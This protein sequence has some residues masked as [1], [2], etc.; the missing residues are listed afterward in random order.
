MILSFWEK[1]MA[2]VFLRM[3]DK[4]WFLPQAMALSTAACILLMAELS[5]KAE[6][7]RL[8]SLAK[9]HIGNGPVSE[10]WLRRPS[11]ERFHSRGDRTPPCGVP[12]IS[13]HS[14]CLPPYTASEVLDLR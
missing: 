5:D 11:K 6:V 2:I 4:L 7:M 13:C 3:N 1:N 12:F 9:P 14:I 10:N 8:A